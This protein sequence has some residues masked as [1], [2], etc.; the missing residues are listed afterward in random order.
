MTKEKLIAKA[1]EV[2]E[3]GKKI[4]CGGKNVPYKGRDL[5]NLIKKVMAR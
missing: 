1:N 2:K 3:K 4:P 5:V